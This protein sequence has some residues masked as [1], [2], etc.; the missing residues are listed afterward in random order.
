MR[1]ATLLAKM[2]SAIALILWLIMPATATAVPESIH[3]S[4]IETPATMATTVLHESGT[5]LDRISVQCLSCHDGVIAS[6]VNAKQPRTLMQFRGPSS[7][8][9]PVGM[10]Y[11]QVAQ[12]KRGAYI[13]ASALD[14]SVTLVNGKVSCV[15]CHTLEGTVGHPDISKQT[16]RQIEIGC[17]SV[18]TLT[19]KQNRQELCLSC[20]VK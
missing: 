2:P 12:R 13:P 4:V 6:S 20:H 3:G 5:T 11:A 10:S 8:D 9:H 15:S 1:Q 18:K 16:Q 14:T 17:V 19:D 7:L